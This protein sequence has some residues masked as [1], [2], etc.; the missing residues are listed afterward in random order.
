[1]GEAKPHRPSPEELARGIAFDYPCAPPFPCK[2][3]IAKP[4]SIHLARAPK[5]L[6]L[7]KDLSANLRMIDR[8][9]LFV[10]DGGPHGLG[11]IRG[12]KRVDPND[13]FFQAHFYQDPVIPGSLGL[14]SLLQLMKLAAVHRWSRSSAATSEGEPVDASP[15]E[16][17]QAMALGEEHSWLYRGQVAPSNELVTVEAAITGFDDRGRVVRAD[18][19]LFVDGVVIYQMS[20]FALQMLMGE[21]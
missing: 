8:V 17:F 19:F 15:G 6:D 1:M 14:E 10:P 4:S 12:A 9:G 2:E 20:D 21:E 3:K 11:F 5:S 13:W 18:G 7:P 16:R